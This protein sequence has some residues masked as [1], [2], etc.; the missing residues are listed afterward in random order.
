MEAAI[1]GA[2]KELADKARSGQIP[3]VSKVKKYI[4]RLPSGRRLK[5][6]VD[7]E[8]EMAAE[9]AMLRPYLIA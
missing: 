4:Y 5:V 1:V 3:V 7:D 2:E 9:L 8:E 6:I